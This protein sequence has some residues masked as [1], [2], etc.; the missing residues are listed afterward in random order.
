MSV[1]WCMNAK[2]AVLKW[3]LKLDSSHYKIIWM[4]IKTFDYKAFIYY[5]HFVFTTCSLNS[6][7][8]D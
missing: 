2:K 1:M 4:D 7:E 5:L 8:R 6:S 3:I